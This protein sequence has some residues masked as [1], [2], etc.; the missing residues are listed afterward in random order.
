MILVP[1]FILILDD[2]DVSR[3]RSWCYLPFG[4]LRQLFK[5]TFLPT[6]SKRA[7]SGRWNIALSHE[8]RLE[9]GVVVTEALLF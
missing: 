8:W 6:S 7:A 5:L 1:R 2:S 4:G 3:D 9:A